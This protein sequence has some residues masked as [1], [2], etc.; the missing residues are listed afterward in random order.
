MWP[1]V[2]NYYYYYDNL[3]TLNRERG[4]GNVSATYK[5][6]GWLSAMA[7]GGTDFYTERR[8]SITQS[9]TASNVRRGQGGQFNQTT[10][11]TR[12]TNLD[13]ILNF[14][15][16]FGNI[17][18]DGLAGANYRDN[19]Y[20]STYLAASNLTVPDLYT[21]SNVKGAPST[22]MFDSEKKTNSVF[23][24][25]NASYKD[26]LFLGVTGRN[27]WSSTL[28]ASNRSYFYP[29]A[30]IGLVITDAFHL[31]SDALSFA[32]I[33]A[34]WA[35]VGGD[36]DPY[37]L[38]RTYS[39]SSF[40][41][42]SLF[43]PTGT[44]PPANLKPQETRSYEIG[45]NLRFIKN[46][47]SLDVTYYDQTTVNQ[48]ISVATSTTTGYTGMKLNA[49]EIENKGV[50][51]MFN[52][53]VL[54]NPSGLNWNL[55]LNW[56]KNK[57]VVNELY[58]ELQSYRI[59]AGFGGAITLGIPGQDWGSIW[60]LPFVR[61]D[62]SGKIVVGD[63]GVPLTTNV[64]KNFGSVTPDWIGGINNAFRYKNMYL[65]FLVDM[66]KGGK[67]F[68]TTAWHSYPTGSYTV[69]TANN[70]R[71]TGLILDAVKQDGTP[72]DV[73]VS[74]E[75]YYGGAW[76]WNNHEYSIL[77]GTYIKLR[78]VILGYNINVK[79]I[80]WLKKLSLSVFGRNLAILY[81][82]KSTA[83]FGIDPEVG[84]GGGDAGV[85]FENFQIPTTRNYGFKL[86][87]GF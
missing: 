48:I 27:D 8:K 29:S 13:F 25:A 70:V 78:E 41:S 52:G 12:E 40:N 24:A 66:R 21:I 28:P 46:R 73:R 85:G 19:V 3:N 6:T 74:A 69:T 43:A 11:F 5:I 37:Q 1:G 80:S 35:K 30:S 62:K 79:N 55:S 20:N 58:G 51:I 4:Y 33:R 83:Q 81:R 9:G 86:S 63:D 65:S 61:D 39:A 72:N 50:E 15:K 44:L 57:N 64:A 60:G 56:A 18:I 47:L 59:S 17:R 32:K 54:D 26:F 14:D 87:A 75:Q 16:S 49:G 23:G 38:S 42:I 53:K 76:V 34:S 71:E 10:I 45:A 84:M 2:D 82:D 77:D 68:S 7:R 36:T 67:F 31:Q 22:S